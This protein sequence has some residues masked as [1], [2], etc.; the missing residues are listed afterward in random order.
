MA[1]FEFQDAL[2]DSV[3][4]FI[5]YPKGIYVQTCMLQTE[6]DG[7]ASNCI[8]VLQLNSG[9]CLIDCNCL[10]NSVERFCSMLW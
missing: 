6:S 8:A 2:I 1:L 5:A 7:K 9:N 4:R 10:Y 3:I